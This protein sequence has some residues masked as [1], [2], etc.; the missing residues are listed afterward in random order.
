MAHFAKV[1]SDNI[2]EQIITVPDDQEGNGQA[3]INESLGLDGRWIQCS[4]N[5][6]IRERFPGPSSL[7]IESLD[8]FIEPAPKPWFILDDDGYWVCPIGIHP[9]TGNPLTDKQWEFLE[10]VYAI[11]PKYPDGFAPW[12]PR[13]EKQ[14]EE[15][16]QR[17]NLSD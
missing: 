12:V 2:V 14:Y 15:G 16:L 17:A 9:E 4:F 10:V 3:F 5:G 8:I 11:K 13:N 1:N 6:S 7:Y